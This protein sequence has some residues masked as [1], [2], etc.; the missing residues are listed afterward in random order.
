MSSILSSVSNQ[1]STA[2]LGGPFQGYSARQTVTNYKDSGNV[3]IRKILTKSWNTPYAVGNVNNRS[4]LVTPFRAVNNLGDYLGRQNYSCG[5][6]NQAQADKP[7]R[8]SR[9][10]SMPVMCDGTGIPAST[11]NVRFVSDSSDYTTFRKQQAMN[12]NY[13][14]LKNGGD[15]NHGSYVSKQGVVRGQ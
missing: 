11:T 13:N 9:I 3:M 12:L 6:S 2:N 15:K 4:R 10:G 7:G 14:D 5:G 1:T 8:K